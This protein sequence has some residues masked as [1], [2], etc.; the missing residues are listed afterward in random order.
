M[1]GNDRPELQD[2][3]YHPLGGVGI[4]QTTD[5]YG[6][7]KGQGRLYVM[8]GALLPGSCACANPSMT[9]AALA[10]R[11]VERIIEEDLG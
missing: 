10:E 11:N 4:G 9:I 5:E 2:F 7:V 6:R 8:D 1:P 3:T